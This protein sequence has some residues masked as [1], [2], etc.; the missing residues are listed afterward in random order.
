[1]ERKE[2]GIFWH[3]YIG[4]HL[5]HCSSKSWQVGR[6]ALVCLVF[7]AHVFNKDGCSRVWWGF[8]SGMRV[9]NARSFSFLIPQVLNHVNETEMKEHTI[10][11]VINYS[12]I[13]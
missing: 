6:S 7:L 1:M 5:S 13:G 12:I 8:W 2:R 10:A 3:V 4:I 9:Q 11:T